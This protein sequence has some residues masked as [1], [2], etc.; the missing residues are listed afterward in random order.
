MRL[1]AQ[2]GFVRLLERIISSEYPPPAHVY[3]D[4][5]NEDEGGWD[6]VLFVACQ[7]NLPNLEV[8]RLLVEQSGVDVNARS[9]MAEQIDLFDGKIRR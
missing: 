8:V 1:L 7:R 4:N 5:F 9:R 2:H 6:P 3:T